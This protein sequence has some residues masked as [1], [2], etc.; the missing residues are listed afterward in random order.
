MEYRSLLIWDPMFCWHG[1]PSNPTNEIQQMGGVDLCKFDATERLD[2]PKP[3]CIPFDAVDLLR[4]RGPRIIAARK[5]YRYWL[6]E[7]TAT[8]AHVLCGPDH[9]HLYDGGRMRSPRHSEG[10]QW[11]PEQ[12]CLNS[13][14][15]VYKSASGIGSSLVSCVFVGEGFFE[16]SFER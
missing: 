6:G 16:V 9:S 7:M 11:N 13:R 12:N 8:G 4:C 14:S 1:T 10:T 3:H 15:R 5:S 2:S